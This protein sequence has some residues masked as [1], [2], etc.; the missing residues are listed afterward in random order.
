VSDP[1]CELVDWPRAPYDDLPSPVRRWLHQRYRDGVP[2]VHSV[3]LVGWAR[4]RPAGRTWVQAE[5]RVAVGFAHT[6]VADLRGGIGRLTFARIL[7]ACVEGRGVSGVGRRRAVGPHVDRAAAV[8]LFA[9]ALMFPAA[10]PHL[11]DLAFA[12][13]SDDGVEVTATVFG[14]AVRATVHFDAETADPSA[15]VTTRDRD[16]DGPPVSWQVR[17]DDWGVHGA[18]AAPGR[19]EVAWADHDEPWLRLR[20]EHVEVDGDLRRERELAY[21]ALAAA[22]S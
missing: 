2:T 13:T 1:V 15:L 4:A 19:I 3:V 5:A 8:A 7:D 6:R 21:K 16:R 22:G 20:V 9:D 11:D 10:W 18:V 12:A 14:T 17:W